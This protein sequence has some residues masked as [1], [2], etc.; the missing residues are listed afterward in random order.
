MGSSGVR[1]K[2]GLHLDCL[3]RL[4]RSRLPLPEFSVPKQAIK[5]WFLSDAI[6]D[7]VFLYSKTAHT[8]IDWIS[9]ADILVLGLPWKI[10]DGREGELRRTDVWCAALSRSHS[11][12]INH[13][14]IFCRFKFTSFC[15]T[16][17]Y[18]LSTVYWLYL[19]AKKEESDGSLVKRNWIE[20]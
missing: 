2:P 4:T 19:L 6:S 13:V 9:D 10:W 14:N 18:Y 15:H 3:P 7:T 1:K 8:C 20:W 12:F 5:A 11:S 16:P 17:P